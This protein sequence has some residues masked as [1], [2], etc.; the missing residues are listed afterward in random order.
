[1]GAP[2]IYLQEIHAETF[3]S[4]EHRAVQALGAT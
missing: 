4:V 3:S 2:A 1:M